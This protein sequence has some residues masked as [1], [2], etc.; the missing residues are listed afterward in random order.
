MGISVSFPVGHE[1]NDFLPPATFYFHCLPWARLL[2]SLLPSKRECLFTQFVQVLCRQLQLIGIGEC[3]CPVNPLRCDSQLPSQLSSSC[4][5]LILP[6]AVFPDTWRRWYRCPIKAYHSTMTC[7]RYLKQP[8]MSALTTVC[9]T[10][11]LFG[12]RQRTKLVHE[13]KH[14]H[15]AGNLRTC[16]FRKTGSR[17]PMA[18]SVMNLS[19]VHSTGAWTLSWRAVLRHNRKS[20]GYPYNRHAPVQAIRTSW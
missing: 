6:S 12:S 18:S 8:G 16:P 15:S 17:F 3:H 2:E 19:Q 13:Y 9:C 20:F 1:D 10:E 14:K 7:S 11:N 5:L 4:S